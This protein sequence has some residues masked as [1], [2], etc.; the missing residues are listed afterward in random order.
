MQN[1]L[2]PRRPLGVTILAVLLTIQG[3][4]EIIIGIIALLAISTIGHIVTAHGHTTIG[5]VVD[6]FGGVLGGISIVVG[7]LTLIF[8]WGMWALKRWAY[9]LTII[10][11]GI[12]LVRHLLEFAHPHP[13]VASIVI[14]L[15][16][17]V[18]ILVYFLA[19]PNV[20]R[21]FRT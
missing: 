15:I 20:H 3:I 6:V 2:A 10:I 21:A 18:V 1:T 16:I 14:G 19:D 5:T 17:P 12:S 4:V 8:A 13:A 11:E 7:V 9:W